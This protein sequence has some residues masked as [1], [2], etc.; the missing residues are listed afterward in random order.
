MAHHT[1]AGIPVGMTP[2]SAP[3]RPL[4]DSLSLDGRGLRMVAEL[5]QEWGHD[6]VGGGQLVWVELA[7]AGS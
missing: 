5:A 2:E 7:T 3:A 6:L 1:C 4:P